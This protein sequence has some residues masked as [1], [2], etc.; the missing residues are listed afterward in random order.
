V[1]SSTL[2][3]EKLFNPAFQFADE[4][5][6]V[7]WLL[8]GQPEPPAYFAQMKRVNKAGPALLAELNAPPMLEGFVLEELI[9]AG[10]TVLDARPES[11]PPSRI[12]GTRIIP[13]SDQFNTYAGWMV[14]YRKPVYLIAEEEDV[15]ELV[16]QLR[17]VGIDEVAGYFTAEVAE[18]YAVALPDTTPAE[19][20]EAVGAG[21]VG[22]LD[23]RSHSEYAE[24]HIPGAIN[25]MYGLLPR[26]LDD[27]ARDRPLLVTCGGGTR[28]LIATSVLLD[29]G[30]SEVVNLG[31]GFDAWRDA[32]LPV[33]VPEGGAD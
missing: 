18:D 12:P 14:D 4:D 33:Q 6:F 29:A 26:H 32:G 13:P 28:S 19:V 25:V 24:G 15:T 21:E 11:R 1:P 16:R 27:I 8:S 22:V 7:H 9:A 20:A 23:V 10:A 17:A 2:G 30:F 3:Y 5:A 31:G